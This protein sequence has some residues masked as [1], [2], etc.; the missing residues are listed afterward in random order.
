MKFSNASKNIHI[1]ELTFYIG[2]L[3]LSVPASS[4]QTMNYIYKVYKNAY[5]IIIYLVINCKL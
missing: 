4:R 5:A 3:E 2:G 1:F